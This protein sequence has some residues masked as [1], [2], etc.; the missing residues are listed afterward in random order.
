[1]EEKEKE[2]ECDE[3]GGHGHVEHAAI[4]NAIVH[5][6]YADGNEVE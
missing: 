1:M 3:N 2:K 6:F 5:V 4:G